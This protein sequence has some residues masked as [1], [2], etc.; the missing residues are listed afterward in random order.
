MT[1]HQIQASF[2]EQILW[3]ENTDERLKLMFAV[4][5][6]GKRDIATAVKLKAEGCRAGVADVMFPYP[7]KGFHGLAIEFKKPVTGRVSKEQSDYLN[8]LGRNGWL[9]AICTDAEAAIKTVKDY[10]R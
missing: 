10:L 1:E 2:F 8:L 9:V 4:P 6:G 5:N 3:M 7:S